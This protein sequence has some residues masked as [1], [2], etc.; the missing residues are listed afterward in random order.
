MNQYMRASKN[1][2]ESE[3]I[4]FGKTEDVGKLDDVAMKG[5]LMA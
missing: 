1:F 4:A 2:A 3:V 5:K